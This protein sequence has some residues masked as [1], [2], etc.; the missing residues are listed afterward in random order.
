MKILVT[1]G[2]GFIGSNLCDRLLGLG[3]KVICIDNL[4]D[5]YS[6]KRKEKNIEH[7]LNNKNFEFHK[8]DIEDK[9]SLKRI[10]ENNKIDIVVHIAARAGVRPSLENPDIYFKTN[11]IGTLNV[12]ELCRQ[13]NI[14]MVFASSSSI[15]GNN[16]IPFS[17]NE[18]AEEQI[19][20]YGTTKR[21]GERLCEMYSNLYNLN[22]ICLRFFTVYGPRGRP[23]MAPYIFTKNILEGKK[24]GIFGDG[25]SQRDY[26]FIEDITDGIV[27]AM[28]KDIK[29]EIINLGDSKPVLLKDFIALI[30]KITGRKA[31]IE[32]LPEQ[33]GDM[34]ATYADI[35]KAK[36]LLGYEPKV[37]IEEGMKKFIEWY[38][39]EKE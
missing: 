13:F 15:Y 26:T 28:K 36:E 14:K 10:F 31:I 5:Y 6:P 21:I 9:D 2:A 37:S 30:E 38:K 20:P 33:K 27:S 17:E 32:N 35:S 3:H 29:F 4:N 34:K 39:N 23:D 19:S 25:S 12:L 11:V 7:N 8:T 24:I 18:P 22:I 16:K 1:G